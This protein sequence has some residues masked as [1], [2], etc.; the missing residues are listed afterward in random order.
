[1]KKSLSPTLQ[2]VLLAFVMTAFFLQSSY[3]GDNKSGDKPNVIIINI[4]D[5]GYGDIGVQGATKVKTPTID[6]LAREGRRFTDFHSAS[7]VC[8]PSRYALLT[9]EYPAR[10]NLWEPIFLGDKLLID[11]QKM[12]LGSLMKKKGYATAVIGKWHLGFGNKVPVDWNEPLKPGPLELGFD[13]YFGVPVLN[14][15]PPYVFVENHHVVGYTPHDPFVY[16]KEADTRYFD[17]KFAYSDIG[18]AKAAHQIYKDRMVGTTLKDKA[19]EWIKANKEHAFFLYFA[20]TNIHHPFTPA[21]RFIGSSEAGPYGDF[22]HEM[23]WMVSEILKTL[24]EEGLTNN[25]LIIFTS[26][27]GPMLNRGGQ[28]AREAGHIA[29]GNWLGFKFDAWEGGHRVPFIAKWP[30]KIPENTV[31]NELCSNVDL[32]ATL[33]SVIGY[34]L[35]KNEGRDSYSMLPALLGTTKEKVRQSLVISP[36]NPQNI[37][38]RK[39]KWVYISGQDGGGFG[40]KEIGKHDFGGAAAFPFSGQINS[41]IADGKI[42][43]DAAPAQLYN[44]DEDPYQSKNLYFSHPEIVTE[45]KEDLKKALQE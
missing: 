7:A 42:K 8:T 35:K 5:L 31:S 44:L 39:G 14:S 2:S 26:D 45:M 21:P 17:E 38:F 3:A 19:V 15:H 36:A 9:G 37:A 32:L 40:G 28:T 30:E 29:N 6:R 27:N 11:T 22:I 25:T 10:K 20:T 1:M 34:K 41:D 33:A 4:D 23:D 43:P 16:G 12:T 24:E 13:Y 18:G